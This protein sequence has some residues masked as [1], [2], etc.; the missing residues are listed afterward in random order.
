VEVQTE[1]R[2]SADTSRGRFLR[3]LALS[4][5]LHVP[6]TPVAAILG[7]LHLI[8][9]PAP[10]EQVP[11]EELTAIPVDLVPGAPGQ[12]TKSDQTPPASTAP[13][14]MKDPFDELEKDTDSDDGVAL[15]P[16][17]GVPAKNDKDAGAGDAGAGGAIGD[18]VALSGTAGK[19][20]DSNANVRLLIFNDRIR[21]HPLGT[22][23][24][25]LLG[26]AEQWQDFFGPTGLD[27]IADVDR[28]LIA[29]PQLKDSSQVVAVL[30]TNVPSTR[31]KSAVD[32]LVQRDPA[33]TWLDAGVPAARAAADNAERL[34]VLPA[35]DIVVI[36]PPG[37]QQQALSL[38][39]KL[40]FPSPQGTEALTTYVI[41]PWRAFVGIPFE[42]PKTI[43]WVRMK[44]TANSDG[45]ATAV[46]VAEDE[47]P[48]LAEEDAKLLSE[49]LNRVTNPSVVVF[50]R[51]VLSQSILDPVTFTAKGAEIH[52][53][54]TVPKKKLESLLAGIAGYSKFLAQ[55]SKKKKAAKAAAQAD[56]GATPA[57]TPDAGT[58]PQE[59]KQ[60]QKSDNPYGDDPRE[61]TPNPQ[62]PKPGTPGPQEPNLPKQQ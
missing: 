42:V 33:G 6:L 62:A 26:A 25:N 45:G 10:T 47:S 31:V 24:G 44:V 29:G 61:Q 48:Q 59:Q 20:A 41:T 43:K 23:I 17:G 8:A 46:I 49:R 21:K 54:V 27:P 30:K 40:G 57:A 4:A 5:V 56:G 22:Q 32:S 38:G 1:W 58:K 55:E 52:G 3:V 36:A 12:G 39:P 18:P 9:A 2:G 53:S 50:G 15:G 60:K 35:P 19:L 34:I 37:V 13:S 51:T 16:D 14:N 7:L 11:E 28:V